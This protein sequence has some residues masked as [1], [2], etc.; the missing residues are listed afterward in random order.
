MVNNKGAF[1]QALVFTVVVFGI[2]LILG[3]FLDSFRVSSVQ[4]DIF[5]SEI[6][7]LDEQLRSRVV[8]D[9]GIGC[10]EAKESVF[11]FADKIYDEARLLEQQ[12]SAAKFT[13][14]LEILH[15]RYDLLRLMLWTEALKLRE[16]CDESFHT[17]VYLYDYSTKEVDVQSRQLFFSRLL[18]DVKDNHPEEILLIPIAGDLGL[19]SVD[20]VKERFGVSELPA[21]IIDEDEVVYEVI[22]LEEIENIIFENSN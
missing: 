10:V 16:K 8:E 3:F 6:N 21:I 4:G 9:F 15:K 17:L 20:L 5:Q 13:N 22:T 12:D 18:L 7:L 2:G 1:W 19:E 11:S 14:N